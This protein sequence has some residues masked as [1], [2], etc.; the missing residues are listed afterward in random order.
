[1]SEKPRCDTCRHSAGHPYNLVCRACPP[2]VIED[3]DRTLR[4]VWPRVEHNDLC[5]AYDKKGEEA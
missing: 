3:Y 5:G 1:M 2:V 4:T